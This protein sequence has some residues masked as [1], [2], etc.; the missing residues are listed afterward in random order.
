MSEEKEMTLEQLVKQLMS[1][2]KAEAKAKAKRIEIEEKIAKLVKTPDKGS[3]TVKA[4]DGFKV[5]VTRGFTY[6]VDIDAL[7]QID[8]KVLPVTMVAAVASTYKFDEKLYEELIK[9]NPELAKKF[10]T[11][12]TVKPKKVS[13]KP[14]IG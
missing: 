10:A 8:A 6:G 1:T 5:T 14:K 2:N 3:K 7:R 9:D 4:G 13:V 12:I 11:C